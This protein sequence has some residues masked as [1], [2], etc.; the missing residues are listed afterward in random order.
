MTGFLLG[1]SVVD[2]NPSDRV[3]L[4]A[5]GLGGLPEYEENFS[6]WAD[7]AERLCKEDLAAEVIRL[8]GSSHRRTDFQ[9]AFDR[10]SSSPGENG[11]CWVFLIGHG[12]YDGRD[13]KF[14]IAG[15][16]LLGS[17]LAVFLDA[18]G[19]R[20]TYTILA[21]SSS[22][23]LT[24]KL[25][26]ANRVV[27]SATKNERE[28]IAPLFMS[29]FLEASRSAEADLDKN[30]SVSLKEAFV[31]SEASI[32]DWY[33]GKKRLQTEHPVLDD[34]GGQGSL[35]SVAY[36]SKPPE[37]SYRSLEARRLVPERVRLEREVEEI[38]LRKTDMTEADYYGRLEEL[39]VELA[40]LNEKIRHL[41]G[42]E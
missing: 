18:M 23:V 31:L 8:E 29:F 14:N 7:S 11:E 13:Y 42:K 39:L 24:S 6:K 1:A 26:G 33:E 17:D 15:P 35:S 34:A 37:Q 25:S 22:G 20:L 38:K 41:E 28:K 10:I 21:T 12:S 9:S 16:D 40:T 32:R 19:D 36:L 4:V 5:S 3:C 30:G 27:V 2:A